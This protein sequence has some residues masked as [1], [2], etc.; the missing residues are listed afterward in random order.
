M[1]G[2]SNLGSWVKLG[3]GNQA[4]VGL[5]ACLSQSMRLADVR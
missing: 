5:Q 4:R 1:E 3:A 2:V